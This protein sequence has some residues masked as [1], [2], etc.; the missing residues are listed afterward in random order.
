MLPESSERPR[1]KA[2][3][4]PNKAV[5]SEERAVMLIKPAATLTSH[6]RGRI[7]HSDT[8]P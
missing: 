2:R 8:V 1:L 3:R 5:R 4:A 7:A 6:K